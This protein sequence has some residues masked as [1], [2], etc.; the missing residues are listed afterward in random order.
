VRNMRECAINDEVW[1]YEIV[2]CGAGQVYADGVVTPACEVCRVRHG[3]VVRP[4]DLAKRPLLKLGCRHPEGCRCQVLGNF[5]TGMYVIENGKKRWLEP[6]PPP[7]T[8]VWDPPTTDNIR[9]VESIGIGSQPLIRGRWTSLLASIVGMLPR[10]RSGREGTL[11][12]AFRPSK[13][14]QWK[15]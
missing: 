13:T 10:A 7:P 9:K 11:Q 2:S 8:R 4:E 15:V 14:E 5:R 6:M 12:K 1:Y 3:M